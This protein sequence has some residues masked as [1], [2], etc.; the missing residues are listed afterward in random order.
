MDSNQ[1]AALKLRLSTIAALAEAQ[2]RKAAD[3]ALE[4]LGEEPLVG[5]NE[6][7]AYLNHMS[8]LTVKAWAKAGKIPGIKPGKEWLFR[9]SEV[10][11]SLHSESTDRWAASPRSR[12]RRKVT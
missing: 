4:L 10:K 7:A 1:D 2:G 9:I 3:V 6:I 5:A 11:T 12:T 8:P